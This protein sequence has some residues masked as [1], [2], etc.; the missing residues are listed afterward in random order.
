MISHEVQGA[1]APWTLLYS[2]DEL[3]CSKKGGRQ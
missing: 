2:D 1:T 3:V